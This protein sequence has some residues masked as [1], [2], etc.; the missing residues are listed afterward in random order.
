MLKTKA[1]KGTLKIL[2]N[3][4]YVKDVRDGTYGFCRDVHHH[5]WIWYEVIVNEGTDVYSTRVQRY[6][7][8]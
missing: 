6:T 3:N 5:Y 1:K 8:F 2:V 4:L 7:Y